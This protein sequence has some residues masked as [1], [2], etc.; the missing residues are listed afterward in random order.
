M[1]IQR[2]ICGDN[3]DVLKGIES[4]SVDLV[5]IDPPFFSQKMYEVVWNDGEEIRQFNDRWITDK[6][7]SESKPTRSSK[8]IDVYLEW[9]E[10]R[11]KEI[12]RVLKPIGSFYLHCDY[13]ADA[14][15]KILC[16]KIFG[17]TQFKADIIW[18]KGFRGTEQQQNYQ[19]AHD[20]ILFYTKSDNYTWNDQ[21]QNYKDQDMK[22]YNKIDENGKKYALIKRRRTNGDVYYGKCYPKEE[23]KRINDIIDVPTMASTSSERLGYPTQKPEALLE[24]IIKASSNENDVIL[25]SFC[26]CGTTLAVAKKLN[27]QFI[28]IDVS[29]TSCRLVAKRL[30][31][32]ID[33][34]EGLPIT[35][36]EIAELDGNEFQNWVIRE[37]GGFSGK[38]GADGGIDGYLGICPIQVKKFKAGRN[39]LD[40]FSG[41]LLRESKKEGIFIALEFSADFRAEVAR[42]KRENE[43]IIHYFDIA[44]VL[45]KR[46]Y[47]IVDQF[48][49]KHGL[50]KYQKIIQCEK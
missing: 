28:G 44:D 35:L 13:H 26:G 42:L 16:D 29:P 32:P 11:L 7:S 47:P 46:H 10:P 48:V 18:N 36:E 5:Y 23:G 6:K 33:S 50:E 30:K 21:F 20:H 31:M 19:R 22:R 1:T 45:A 40:G 37:F 43:V 12:Y 14:Y 24:Y 27:R 17:Y 2:I 39:V 38:R 49:E 9:M 8:N 4:E 41:T 25:D 34:I 3:A 15:L